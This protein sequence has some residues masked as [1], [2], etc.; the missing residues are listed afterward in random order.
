MVTTPEGSSSR[1][2]CDE[3]GTPVTP[4]RIPTP[5]RRLSHDRGAGCAISILAPISRPLLIAAGILGVATSP[6]VAR[7]QSIDYYL[8]PGIP[9][10]GQAAGVTVLTRTHPEYQSGGLRVGGFDL[11][12]N[13]DETVGYNSNVTAN[14]GGSWFLQNAPAVQAVSNGSR[15]QVGF[16]VTANNQEYFD[17]P[18]LDRTD[19]T[20]TIG[21]ATAIGQ[22]NL[23]VG[24]THLSLSSVGTGLGQ[25]ATTTYIPYT[26]D[27]ARVTYNYLIGRFTLTP[28]LDDKLFSFGQGRFG[29]VL[30]DQKSLNRNVLSG[31][32]TTAYSL[33]E[34]EDLLLVL[35]GIDSHYTN[36]ISG[37]PS[38]DSQSF[39]A[40]AGIDVQATGTIRYRLLGGVE[41]RTFTSSIYNTQTSPI[42]EASL[43]WTPTGL[44]TVTGIVSREID[45]PATAGTG[46]FTY[47]NAQLVVDHELYRNILLQGRLGYQIAEYV[48]GGGLGN[49]GGTQS[50]FNAGASVNWL[51]N[52]NLRLSLDYNYVNQG[53]GGP[54]QVVFNGQTTVQGAAGAYQQSVIGLTLHIGL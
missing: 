17:S 27:D 42:A 48:G 34:Q 15:T 28:N 51:L 32:L 24:Y 20:A 50:A 41:L 23:N 45:D 13:L 54:R 29:N 2:S 40:L 39:Q 36:A 18:S 47:T 11:Q 7:A 5:F 14:G 19:W 16:G 46:G 31:G 37:Q 10:F 3:I 33:A 43:V 35:Q 52:R 44:T 1:P 53:A 6:G 9:G 38:A 21:G 12:A 4:V 49:A 25:Q 8:P 30:I 22:G 26:V